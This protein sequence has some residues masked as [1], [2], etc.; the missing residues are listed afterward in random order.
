[1]PIMDRKAPGR[2]LPP[3]HR[4][5]QPQLFP[6]FH[7]EERS[8]AT[9]KVPVGPELSVGQDMGVALKKWPQEPLQGWRHPTW[10]ACCGW[11][12]AEQPSLLSLPL[13]LLFRSPFHFLFHKVGRAKQS[14]TVQANKDPLPPRT[15][16]ESKRSIY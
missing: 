8:R 14:E 4:L 1:M 6:A 15:R 5:R 3:D 9:D 11:F 13:H 12:Q 10:S 2:K 7:E 16:N